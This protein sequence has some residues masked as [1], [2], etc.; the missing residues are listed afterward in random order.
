MNLKH[1]RLFHSLLAQQ[2]LLGLCKETVSGRC[3]KLEQLER[4]CSQLPTLLSHVE[5]LIKIRSN[6]LENIG[7]GQRSLHATHRLM[8]M[9]ICAK[10]R[11][12]QK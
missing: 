7:Q 6:D 3:L 4:L 8:L 12:S 9:M 1:N 5:S 10:H 11:F 2:T